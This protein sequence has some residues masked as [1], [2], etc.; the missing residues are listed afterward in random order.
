MSLQGQKNTHTQISHY[1]FVVSPETKVVNK[2][3]D[4]GVRSRP[5]GPSSSDHDLLA[6]CWEMTVNYSRAHTH[7][8]RISQRRSISWLLLH[9]PHRTSKPSSSYPPAVSTAI[10]AAPAHPHAVHSVFQAVVS[11]AQHDTTE[12][13]NGGQ[14]LVF[15]GC[16]IDRKCCGKFRF[17]HPLLSV[18]QT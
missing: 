4:H 7:T 18:L 15:L 9:L 11:K 3:G 13:R 2:P 8:K 10:P 14:W 1:V 17:H 5:V 12:E 6:I 16:S